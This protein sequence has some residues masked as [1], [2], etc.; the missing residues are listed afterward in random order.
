MKMFHIAQKKKKEKKKKTEKFKV[1]F[2]PIQNP[3]TTSLLHFHFSFPLLLLFLHPTPPN[4]I[5]VPLRTV[6]PM[7]FVL[8]FLLGCLVVMR[9]Q[10]ETAENSK[11]KKINEIQIPSW[12]L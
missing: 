2:S 3:P 5:R 11:V 1:W 12:T 8:A 9:S 10:G 6:G 7:L 4:M